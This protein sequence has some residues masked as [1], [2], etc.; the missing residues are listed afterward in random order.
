MV[1]IRLIDKL[2]GAKETSAQGVAI[3]GVVP[4][5]GISTMTIRKPDGTDISVG[6]NPVSHGY[7]RMLGLPLRRGRWFDESS[8]E[9][10]VVLINETFARDYFGDADPLGKPLAVAS[11]GA[12]WQIIGIVERG[13]ATVEQIGLM[14][15]GI[16]LQD[17][18]QN[19]PKA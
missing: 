8:N 5:A 4:L 10:P 11:R 13:Q 16:S 9:G 6:F 12:P 18:L 7:R 3:T 19:Q 14:M 17:A 15:A 2:I 1:P